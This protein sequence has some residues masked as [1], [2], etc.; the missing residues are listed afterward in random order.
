MV[1]GVKDAQ[2]GESTEERLVGIPNSTE[3][4]KHFAE[5]I[6]KAE[7]SIIFEHTNPPISLSEG[8]NVIL[9]I[10]IPMSR[11]G[12]HVTRDGMFY[13]RTNAG[14]ELMS[15][16]EIRTAFTNYEERFSKV[17]LLYLTLIDIWIRSAQFK[18]IGDSK[19]NYSLSTFDTQTIM[20]IFTD[21]YG[22][23]SRVSDLTGLIMEIRRAADL[24]DTEV[25]LFHQV[26]VFPMSGRADRTLKHN[27]RMAAAASE[28]Q[29]LVGNALD[30][31]E[32]EFGFRRE[33]IDSDGRSEFL[34]HNV[35]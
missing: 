12:P 34:L 22:L 2:T 27:S 8:E 32:A 13:K 14:N 11:R 6:T 21:V 19:S 4:A 10:H 20:P 29:T 18:L 5:A 3:L 16:A 25:R 9:V 31:M 24:I 17:K 33:Q 23:I 35:R 28:L 7:P 30:M 15:Y 1:F 26:S